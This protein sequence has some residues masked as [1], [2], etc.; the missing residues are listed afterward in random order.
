MT[1]DDGVVKET[2]CIAM[3]LDK[4]CPSVTSCTSDGVKVVGDVGLIEPLTINVGNG[5]S[6]DD[7]DV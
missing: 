6:D 4:K 5:L 7:C 1:A 2:T 3:D